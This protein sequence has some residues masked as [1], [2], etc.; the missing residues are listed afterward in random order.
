MGA[1]GEKT[2]ESDSALDYFHDF[3][4]SNQDIVFLETAFETIINNNYYLD[5]DDCSDALAA[6]EILA[7][8]K[9]NQSSDFPSE[10]HFSP[11]IQTESLIEQLNETIFA[12]AFSYQIRRQGFLSGQWVNIECQAGYAFFGVWENNFNGSA[13]IRS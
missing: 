13:K 5:A 4:E 6:G 9:G 11:F 2:F 8:L 10:E 12:N 3:C 1:W 7:Y